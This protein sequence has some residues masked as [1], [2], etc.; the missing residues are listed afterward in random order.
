MA[1]ST[2]TSTTNA[3]TTKGT[4]SN[5]INLCCC[6]FLHRKHVFFSTKNIRF[7]YRKYVFFFA[8]NH[9]IQSRK[10]PGKCVFLTLKNYAFVTE[11]RSK[12]LYLSMPRIP[13]KV[14]L[15]TIN[16]HITCNLCKGYL[17]NATTIVECL[18]SCKLY[19]VIICFIRIH[20]FFVE[21][22][23]QTKNIVKKCVCH[24]LQFLFNNFCA[25]CKQK[26]SIVCIWYS[27]CI[28]KLKTKT[29]G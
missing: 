3:V 17:I 24:V 28:V 11:S 23:C 2:T 13:P 4:N 1:T 20:F 22:P 19:S 26:K 12:Q 16:P 15:K 14:Y 7:F 21:I 29:V 25:Q 6:F 27:R 8:N 18:H 9:V 10:I 5:Q